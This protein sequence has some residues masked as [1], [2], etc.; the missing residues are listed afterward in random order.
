MPAKQPT[1][2]VLDLQA[3]LVKYGVKSE[4]EH[5]D[6]HKHVDLFIPEAKMYIEVD[7]IK[8]LTD[9]DQIMADFNREYYSDINQFNTLR[10]DNDMLDTYFVKIAEV[11]AEVVLTRKQAL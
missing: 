5:W 10:I 11:I 6:G 8:H 3:E 1:P 2:R 4:T 7:G 9:P